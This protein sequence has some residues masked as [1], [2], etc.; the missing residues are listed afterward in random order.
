M[1]YCTG[2]RTSIRFWSDPMW[3]F[4]RWWSSELPSYHG[5]FSERETTLSPLSAEIGMIVRSGMSS[6]AAKARKSSA[7]FW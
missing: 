7:T 5:M 4:S 6:L 3:M 2:K 1:T